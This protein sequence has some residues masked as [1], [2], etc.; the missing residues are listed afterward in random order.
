MHDIGA[1]SPYCTHNG[2]DSSQGSH[3]LWKSWKT[4][5]I[6]QKKFHAWKNHGILLNNLTKP[7]EARKLAVRHTKLVSDSQ[8]SGY[9]WFQVL[10]IPP[11]TL[12]VVGILF[13]CCPSV[14]V[15]VTF[16][17]LNILKSH[18]CIFIKPYKHVHIC[19][20]NTLNKT[21]RARG[22]FYKSYFPL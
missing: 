16:C 7:P 18:C 15:Y 12:F 9:W 10:I 19:K 20:T 2:Q 6:T 11:Q 1:C 13:S 21:V 17:F 8:F 14:R 22:Q 4:S 5:K 3:K